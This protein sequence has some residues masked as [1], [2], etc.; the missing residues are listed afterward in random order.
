MSL[1][2]Q[3]T[4]SSKH[5]TVTTIM[6]RAAATA[7]STCA[8]TLSPP[9]SLST[10]YGRLRAGTTPFVNVSVTFALGFSLFPGSR[11][12]LGASCFPEPEYA[13]LMERA[14][15]KFFV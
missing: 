7:V 4:G 14:G 8:S 6:V 10:Y 13:D 1:L 12:D 11:V 2:T 3:F 5:S 9:F 15:T